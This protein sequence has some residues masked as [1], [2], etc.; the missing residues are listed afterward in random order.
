MQRVSPRSSITRPLLLGVATIGIAALSGCGGGGAGSAGSAPPPVAGPSPSPAP[1]PAPSPTPPPAPTP[2]P[3]PGAPPSPATTSPLVA[4]TPPTPSP[5]LPAASNKAVLASEA[6]T[7]TLVNDSARVAPPAAPAARLDTGVATGS[8]GSFTQTSVLNT[9]SGALVGTTSNSNTRITTL[10]GQSG[11]LQSTYRVSTST[12][13]GITASSATYFVSNY[14]PV[15][16]LTYTEFG[17]WSVNATP[18]APIASYQGVY[19]GANPGG[20]RTPAEAMPRTGTASYSG[21]AAG[22]LGQASGTPADAASGPFYGTMT[23]TA[24]FAASSFSG[25][26]TGINVYRRGGDNGTVIGTANDVLFTGAISGSTLTGTA[27]PGA[28]AGSAFNLSGATG[29]IAGA[30]FGPAAQ[31]AAG[32]FSL[33]GGPQGVSLVGSF[34]TKRP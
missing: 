22:Y 8:G 31:E 4:A 23:L 15:V 9:G 14:A 1:T 6:L 18:T 13:P 28:A 24:D 33:F 10:N 30:F 34:G 32:T 21:G 3:T 5:E 29:G 16:R 11:V 2:T 26:V 19:A 12:D 17:A 20:N 25:G 27:T 7:V